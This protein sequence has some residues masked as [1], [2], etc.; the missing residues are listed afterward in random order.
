MPSAWAQESLA[1]RV[2][3]EE[4][5]RA[6]LGKLSATELSELDALFKKYGPATELPSANAAASARA[7]EIEAAATQRA[8]VRV[9]EA[10]A[11]AKKA[12]QEAAAAR[13]AVQTANKTDAKE[14]EGLLSK[15]RKVLVPAG[16][17]VEV[18]AL[19]TTIDGAFDGWGATTSWRMK[20]G[21]VWQVE[22]RPNLFA[23]PKVTNPRVRI[24]PAAISGF[25]L[26]LPDLGYQVR[27]R[28][29][30]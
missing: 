22:N 16:T 8:A 30:K 17:K 27:V 20:D 10:E 1:R 23:V 6:G 14:R 26:E 11:R 15:A 18:A 19:E 9:A 5:T 7:A 25:W 21:T 4:F 13:E 3:P 29:L 24:Y 28:Q 2:T 12:E